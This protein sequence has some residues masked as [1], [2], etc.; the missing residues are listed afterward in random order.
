MLPVYCFT[1]IKKQI[2]GKLVT[3]GRLLKCSSQN[4]RTS[5]GFSSK[6]K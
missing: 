6:E 1:T 3:P 4:F 5:L 2:K